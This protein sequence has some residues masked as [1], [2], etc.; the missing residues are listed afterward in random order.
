MKKRRPVIL[1]GGTDGTVAANRLHR[2]LP[3]WGAAA[4]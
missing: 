3:Y 1:G 2:D 4:R